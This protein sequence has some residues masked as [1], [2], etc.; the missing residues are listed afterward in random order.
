[1]DFMFTFYLLVLILMGMI[2]YAGFEGTLRV[3]A[4]LD[5]QMRFMVIKFKMWQMKRKLEKQL[6]L[7][8]SN[9]S[10]LIKDLTNGK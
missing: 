6:D 2:W 10:T 9:F 1:M 7:P 8:P 5:M 3:F 4:Y